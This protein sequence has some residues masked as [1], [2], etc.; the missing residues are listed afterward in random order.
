MH[1]RQVKYF[2][3]IIKHGGIIVVGTQLVP[4]QRNGGSSAQGGVAGSGSEASR[5]ACGR[6]AELAWEIVESTKS[7]YVCV[8]KSI[9]HFGI[10]AVNMIIQ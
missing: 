1:S 6:V 7:C 2:K 3:S 9:L 10:T 4:C 5:P 8:L